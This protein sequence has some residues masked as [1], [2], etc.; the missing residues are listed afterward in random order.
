METSAGSLEVSHHYCNQKTN[1]KVSSGIVHVFSAANLQ[2]PIWKRRCF[3]D[4]WCIG[5]A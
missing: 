4:R 3:T 5:F 1:Q 2:R